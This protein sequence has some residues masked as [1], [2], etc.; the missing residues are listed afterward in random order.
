M[1]YNVNHEYCGLLL[2]ALCGALTMQKNKIFVLENLFVPQEWE[3]LPD[4]TRQLLG[5]E[6][7]K[8]VRS[9]ACAIKVLDKKSD[10]IQQ[11]CIADI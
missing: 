6:F 5:K 3:S 1:A 9:E 8:F 2:K 11:Y 7:Y 10:G 4:T